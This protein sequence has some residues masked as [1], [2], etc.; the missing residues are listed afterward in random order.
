ML[1]ITDLPTNAKRWTKSELAA[2][3]WNTIR[4]LNDQ[5]PSS[6]DLECFQ[7]IVSPPLTQKEPLLGVFGV[8][9]IGHIPMNDLLREDD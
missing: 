5:T 6:V 8:P 7:A 9:F 4:K 2:L 1:A 3:P